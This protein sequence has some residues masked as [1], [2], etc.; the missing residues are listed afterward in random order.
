MALCCHLA[1]VCGDNPD[2]IE[3]VARRS[4][5]VRPK[6]D[7]GRGNST[8]LRK[9]ITKAVAE[10]ERTASC[11]KPHSFDLPASLPDFVLPKYGP[12]VFAIVLVI[13]RKT[14]TYNKQEDWI[15]YSQMV[16]ATSLSRT[17]VAFHLK[18]LIEHQFVLRRVTGSGR[19]QRYFYSL[20]WDLLNA[21]Y[22][23]SEKVAT[24][25]ICVG[26]GS[27]GANHS[28]TAMLLPESIDPLSSTCSNTHTTQTTVT[29]VC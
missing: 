11:R 9:T 15:S 2:L 21:W 17:T 1:R 3:R 23:S 29:T 5:L 10:I 20:N 24:N 7:D 28:S 25:K 13:W 8:Y 18:T 12:N 27:P 22:L 19:N 16:L 6:W 14:M 26:W 4:A